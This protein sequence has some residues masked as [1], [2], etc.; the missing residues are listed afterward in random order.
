[1]LLFAASRTSSAGCSTRGRRQPALPEQPDRAD[2]GF[3]LC[4]RRR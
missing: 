2:V 1:M 3:V 4:G